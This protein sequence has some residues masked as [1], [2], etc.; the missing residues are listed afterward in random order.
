M[1]AALS[2]K[3]A[4]IKKNL[5]SYIALGPVAY[6][7]HEESRLLGSLAHTALIKVFSSLEIKEIF[8]SKESY[9]MAVSIL[10]L[11]D[12]LICTSTLTAIS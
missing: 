8:Y 9:R 12:P 6:L 5:A 11:Y 1:F 7:E 4:V 2:E 3:N 10:C